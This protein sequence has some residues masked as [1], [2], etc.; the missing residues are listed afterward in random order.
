LFVI[1]KY[2][3][4]TKEWDVILE[5]RYVKKVNDLVKESIGKGKFKVYNGDKLLIRIHEAK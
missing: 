4:K 3:K 2:N 5:T 1:K